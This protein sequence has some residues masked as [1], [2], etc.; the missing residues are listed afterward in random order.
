MERRTEEMKL[1]S[2]VSIYV[3]KLCSF[4]QWYFKI[5]RDLFHYLLCNLFKYPEGQIFNFWVRL[6]R[7]I[8]L[9]LNTVGYIMANKYSLYKFESDTYE[10][11]GMKYSGIFFRAFGPDGFEEGAIFQIVNRLDECITIRRVEKE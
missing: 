4:W 6:M 10:I 5:R 11:E 3:A 8:I 7:L 1:L 9:P 2:I